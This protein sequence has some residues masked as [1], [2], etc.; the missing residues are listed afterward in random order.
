MASTGTSSTLSLVGV[1]LDVSADWDEWIKMIKATIRD[2]HVWTYIYLN[3][4]NKPV[5]PIKLKKPT[6]V[7]IKKG[8]MIVNLKGKD[9]IK[10]KI[11]YN[12]YKTYLA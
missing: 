6:A 12:K 11:L 8:L 10:Y 5:I 2:A 4:K 7:E 1:I 9:L 3:S